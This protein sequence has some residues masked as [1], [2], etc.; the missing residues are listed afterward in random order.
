V[1]EYSVGGLC[2]C[3][4]G[5]RTIPCSGSKKLT[6]HAFTSTTSPNQHRPMYRSGKT[7]HTPQ[8]KAKRN[9]R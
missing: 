7:T 2:D 5:A 1:L 3:K 6:R 4:H 9:R 8:P